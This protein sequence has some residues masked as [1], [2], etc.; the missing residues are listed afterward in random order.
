MGIK[1]NLHKAY[2]R[3]AWYV[4]LDV[5]DAYGFDNKFKLL[6]FKCVSSMKVRMLL[7][8]STYG[9]VRVEREIRQ[10]DPFSFFLFVLFLEIMSRIIN[11]L[12]INGEIQGIKV[13]RIAPSIT[14]LFFADD[15]LIFCK[16]FIEQALKII[17][18]LETFYDRTGQSF[19]PANSGCF[20]SKIIRGSHKSC[21]QKLPQYERVRG[22][23]EISR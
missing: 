19:N 20:F 8:D 5:L 23:C 9:H 16:A 15:F 6:I 1:I 22:G 14:H 2:D 7:N 4:L 18:C 12:E 10:R 3:I 17:N 21:N 13:T 11:K